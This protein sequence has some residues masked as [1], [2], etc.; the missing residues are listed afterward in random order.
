MS[1]AGTKGPCDAGTGHHSKPALADFCLVHSMLWMPA[2]H[3]PC[4]DSA[5]PSPAASECVLQ[6]PTASQ[7]CAENAGVRC[8]EPVL[9]A[10]NTSQSCT[11]NAN[12]CRLHR[13]CTEHAHA[14]QPFT[15]NVTH[16]SVVCMKVW[17]IAARH[18]CGTGACGCC[19][20][21]THNQT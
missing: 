19:R 21:P 17:H 1:T 18:Q 20:A 15:T 7:P 3:Q 9:W 2:S 16:E 14:K 4:T 13:A 5:Q 11:E 10:P 12:L 8:A 6:A